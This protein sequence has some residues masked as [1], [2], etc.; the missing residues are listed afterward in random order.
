MEW[1]KWGGRKYE[2]GRKWKRKKWN[3]KNGMEGKGKNGM[4]GNGMEGKQIKWKWR[5][6]V[7]SIHA[8]FHD[9]GL[10]RLFDEHLGDYTNGVRSAWSA[11]VHTKFL[12][13][14]G[15]RQR[16]EDSVS[17]MHLAPRSCNFPSCTSHSVRVMKVHTKLH[18]RS[19][20]CM[21]ETLF[22]FLC[23]PPSSFLVSFCL[24]SS[25]SPSSS[26]LPPPSF[27]PCFLSFFFLWRMWWKKFT[28]R[29]EGLKA[30]RKEMVER[31]V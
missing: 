18:E 1:K 25:P 31:R 5:T 20:K 7:G 3:E 29:K 17:F 14:N 21:K 6:Y 13:K 9:E 26:L 19:A 24:P 8:H 10:S 4:E 11:K 15:G 2:N 22:S 23:L 16:K 28:W 30:Q 27:P 12:S